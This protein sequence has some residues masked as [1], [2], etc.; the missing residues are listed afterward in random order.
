[1]RE[2]ERVRAARLPVPDTFLNVG[3]SVARRLYENDQ[4]GPRP[5]TR[6]AT[7][8]ALKTP[9]TRLLRFT[10][11][12]VRQ[13]R[14]VVEAAKRLRRRIPGRIARRLQTLE[15]VVVHGKQVVAQTRAR[16]VR[17]E[18]QSAGK[19]VSIFEPHTQIL[20]RGKKA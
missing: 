17:G 18:T 6:E 9:Y 4:L 13:A 1:C 10:G 12:L 5:T 16:I 14:E 15:G 20:R 19:L 3:P 11:R 8:E 7:L 2:M